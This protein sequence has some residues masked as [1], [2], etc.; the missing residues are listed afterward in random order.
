[1]VTQLNLNVRDTSWNF[2][3]RRPISQLHVREEIYSD[4]DIGVETPIVNT[5]NS[6]SKSEFHFSFPVYPWYFCKK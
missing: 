2:Q 5:G 3:V 1:M 6:S 4:I